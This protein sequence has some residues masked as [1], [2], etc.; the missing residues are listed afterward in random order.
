M[1]SASG[2]IAGISA[3]LLAPAVAAQ[4]QDA[5]NPFVA[6]P[7]PGFNLYGN[8]GLIDMPT[9][10][11]APDATLSTTFAHFA[12]TTRNTLTFQVLPRLSGSFRYTSIDGLVIPGSTTYDGSATYYD[13]SFDLRYQ[14]LSE[15]SNRPALSLGL[16]DFIGTG[17]YSSEYIVASKAIT[18]ALR[19]TGGLGWGRLGSYGAIGSMGS[20][21]G[22]TIGKGGIPTYDRWFRGDFA[23][24]GGLEWRA[25]D[26]L[27][28]KAEYSSDIYSDE[29][30]TSGLFDRKSPWNFGVDYRLKNGAQLSLYS[31]YG[32]EIG[33]QI[34]FHSNPR[35]APSPGGRN[36]APVPVKP[37]S[38]AERQD[39]GWSKDNVQSDSLRTRLK[40]AL[41][42]DGLIFE[43]LE[44]MPTRAIL[45]FRNPLYMEEPQAFGRAARVMT[46]ILPGSV[47]TLT[48][49]PIVDGMTT[50]AVTFQRSDLERLEN[51]PA[52]ELLAKTQIENGFERAPEEEEGLYPALTWSF[53]PY[54]ELSIFDPDNPMRADVGLQLQGDYH[55]T[56]N[57]V[58]SGAV[59]KKL[60]G[61]LSEV[62]RED[63]T[64]LPRVRTDY[65]FYNQ[66]GDPAIK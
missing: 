56:P 21:P 31:L 38:A 52:S 46:R 49:V 63:P 42:R 24:F 15:S 16:R 25:S 18:P 23:P 48:L 3:V 6:P 44:L 26:R 5:T 45:R 34:T 53:G 27:S 54:L 32:G 33:A 50:S 7:P 47:E 64:G 29:A 37:R 4:D 66:Q 43:G 62:N 59:R 58:L 36:G 65:P 13:R 22:A 17:R 40:Q 30:A 57:W 41:D 51:A 2:V 39:L 28:F 55:I 14:L 10:D 11:M 35:F 60:L 61:N 19:I 9:A 8:V 12:G 1:A 20:R